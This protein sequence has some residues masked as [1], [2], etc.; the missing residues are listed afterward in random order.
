MG[1]LSDKGQPVALQYRLCIRKSPRLDSSG[2]FQVVTS[3][4][5][6]SIDAATCFGGQR[7]LHIPGNGVDDL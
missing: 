1:T 2:S 5:P 7:S 4:A 6:R 3:W